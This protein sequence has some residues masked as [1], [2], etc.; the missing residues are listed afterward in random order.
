[1]RW[2]YCFSTVQ[3]RTHAT[4]GHWGQSLGSLAPFY[5]RKGQRTGVALSL[6]FGQ[7]LFIAPTNSAPS[8]NYRPASVRANDK[9]G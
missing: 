6:N 2:L 8:A 5:G 7:G 3:Q 1:M 4:G 9:V